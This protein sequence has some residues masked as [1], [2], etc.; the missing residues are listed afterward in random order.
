[1]LCWA[2]LAVLLC[3]AALLLWPRFASTTT[4]ALTL[5]A[6][7]AAAA[8]RLPLGIGHTTHTLSTLPDQLP[9][10]VSSFLPTFP[11]LFSRHH[12]LSPS[13][14]PNRRHLSPIPIQCLVLQLLLCIAATPAAAPVAAPRPTPLF[15]PPAP[16]LLSLAPPLLLAAARP[17]T[18]TCTPATKLLL[19]VL[20]GGAAA[21]RPP[22]GRVAATLPAACLL[23]CSLAIIWFEACRHALLLPALS[24]FQTPTTRSSVLCGIMMALAVASAVSG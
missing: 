13:P 1:M 16:P 21:P 3:S 15:T 23:A 14:S 8:A 11:L 17:S 19:V 12:H 5:C 7:A 22:Q 9:V 6:A 24:P 20:L 18:S 4:D 2:L 10:L